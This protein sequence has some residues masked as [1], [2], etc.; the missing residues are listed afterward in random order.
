MRNQTASEASPEV[1]KVHNAFSM[2]SISDFRGVR[3]LHLFKKP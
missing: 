2:S 1:G 3:N